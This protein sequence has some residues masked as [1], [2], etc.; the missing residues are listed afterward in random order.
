M[1]LYDSQPGSLGP[2]L[3]VIILTDYG[4]ISTGEERS[5]HKERMKDAE[6]VSG[7]MDY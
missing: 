6:K 2:A 3:G 1:A 7:S 4:I 5:E